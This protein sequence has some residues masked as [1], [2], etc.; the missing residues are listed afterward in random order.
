M[1]MLTER[2]DMYALPIVRK[3]KLPTW[4][5]VNLFI[6]PPRKNLSGS[7]RLFISIIQVGIVVEFDT[8]LHKLGEH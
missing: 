4:L 7:G 5:R 3:S 1:F 8:K 6:Q 2:K